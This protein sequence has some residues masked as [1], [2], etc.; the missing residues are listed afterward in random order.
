LNAF[1]QS[2]KAFLYGLTGWVQYLL[3]TVL[4]IACGLVLAELIFRSN[5]VSK[6]GFQLAHFSMKMVT[7]LFFTLGARWYANKVTWGELAFASYLGAAAT[8]NLSL[9]Y[10][11]ADVISEMLV[12]Q[13]LNLIF[14]ALA[15]KFHLKRNMA[16]RHVA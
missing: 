5:S 16:Q 11:Y 4:I 9:M 7:A 13:G 8:L 12:Y 10:S 15:V 1:K 2:I 3:R 6:A 14:F